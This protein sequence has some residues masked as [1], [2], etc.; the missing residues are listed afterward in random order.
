VTDDILSDL[1]QRLSD[2]RQQLSQVRTDLNRGD[3]GEHSLRCHTCRQSGATDQ[4]GWTLRL[5]ADD[6]LHAFCPDCDSRHL[7]PG[8]LNGGMPQSARHGM[9]GPPHAR[10][11]STVDDAGLPL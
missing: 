9:H 4:A 8:G 1:A 11:S 3:H 10:E 5:C 2:L 6:E 7:N